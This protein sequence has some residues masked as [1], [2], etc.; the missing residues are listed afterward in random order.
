MATN[1]KQTIAVVGG[2]AAGFFAAIN[3][4][5]KCPSVDVIILEKGS[6]PLSKVALTGGGRCNITNSF[7]G[8][9]SFA[10]IYPR[11]E[12]L[13]QRGFLLF[14]NKKTMTWFE[15]HGVHLMTQDDNRVFPK[16]QQSTEIINTFLSLS[17]RLGI[18]IRCNTKVTTIE[19]TPSAQDCPESKFIINYQTSNNNSN[20]VT[21]KSSEYDSIIAD[22]VVFTIGGCSKEHLDSIFSKLSIK[23]TNTVPSL[24]SFN[25]QDKKVQAMTGTSVEDVCI[26]LQGTKIKSSGALLFTHWGMS[27]PAI[28]RLSSYSAM[29]MSENYYKNIISVNWLGDKNES[30]IAD[31]ITST[32]IKQG[33]KQL[34]SVRIGGLPSK[35]WTYL[36]EK[37]SLDETK[38][39]NEIGKKTI[40]QLINVL[41]NDEYHVDGKNRFKDEFVTC[42]G[43]S[44]KSISEKSLEC[45][46]HKGLYFAGE[47]L[48]IDAITGGFNLQAAWTTAFIVANDIYLH[49]TE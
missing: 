22:K 28:L 18:I 42:G 30:E 7:D 29:I 26:K 11:G 24:F 6:S 48:D 23:T 39:W 45:K 17:Q 4:K 46:N 43:V 9:K 12:R 36:L 16:S 14:D 2:G 13:M 33:G 34:S 1:K 20:N 40:N 35:L 3:I 25:I 32:I 38:R 41:S 47:V 8:V 5:E 31:E 10:S 37:I 19:Q 27:G 44:L 15:D 21:S 49:I